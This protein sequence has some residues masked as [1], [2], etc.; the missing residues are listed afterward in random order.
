MGVIND[1]VSRRRFL[2]GAFMGFG[3]TLGLGTLALRFFQFLIPEVKAARFEEV[4]V[5]LKS[6]I[7]SGGLTMEVGGNPLTIL[8]AGDE[9]VA[10]SRVCTDLGCLV[11]WDK[12]GERF[13]CPCHQGIYDRDGKNISGPPPRPLDRFEVVE[14]GK[15]VYV[16]VKARA[17]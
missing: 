11:S 9:V 17:V 8:K 13:V 15:H 3:L 6:A 16:K 10:F 4:L 1:N 7:P 14:K 5:G 12:V 2:S